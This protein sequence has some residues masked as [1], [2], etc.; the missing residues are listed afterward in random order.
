MT[1]KTTDPKIEEQNQQKDAVDKALDK[2][3]PTQYM[4]NLQIDQNLLKSNVQTEQ[5]KTGVLKQQA[6]NKEAKEQPEKKPMNSEEYILESEAGIVNISLEEYI[7]CVERL[8]ANFE[9]QKKLIDKDFEFK[10]LFAWMSADEL[11]EA[12]KWPNWLDAQQKKLV[13]A[14]EKQIALLDTLIKNKNIELK[15][16]VMPVLWDRDRNHYLTA[17]TNLGR[18]ENS[19]K[20]WQW[21][22]VETFT[23]EKGWTGKKAITGYTKVDQNWNYIA[24]WQ[25]PSSSRQHFITNEKWEVATDYE[26]TFKRWWVP[27]VN[28][29]FLDTFWNLSPKQKNWLAGLMTLGEVA[30][31]VYLGRKAIK[32]IATN[33]DWT[34]S[35]LKALWWVAGI[36]VGSM[37]A[38]GKNP[39]E[40]FG[41]FFNGK[42][43]FDDLTNKL[44]N[45]INTWS[46]SPELTQ[47]IQSLRILNEVPFNALS[48]DQMNTYWGWWLWNPAEYS[49]WRASNRDLMAKNWISVETFDAMFP[50]AIT[51]ETKG[52]FFAKLWLNYAKLSDEEK[53]LKW[54]DVIQRLSDNKELLNDYLSKNNLKVKMWK[55]SALNSYLVHKSLTDHTFTQMWEDGVLEKNIVSSSAEFKDAK[56]SLA[57]QVDNLP[58]LSDLSEGKKQEIKIWIKQFYNSMPEDN[59]PKFDLIEKNGKIYL[60]S[61]R[62][63]YG[64]A[65]MLELNLRDGKLPHF[66]KNDIWI[67]FKDYRWLFAA[68]YATN[69]IINMTKKLETKSQNP[70]VYR[71]LKWVFKLQ[72]FPPIAGFG[73]YFDWKEWDEL[74]LDTQIMSDGLFGWW[75]KMEEISPEIRE[76]SSQYVNY[77][78]W[79]WNNKDALKTT[80]NSDSNSLTA[81]AGA[82]WTIATNLTMNN[83]EGK[84]PEDENKSIEYD[85]KNNPYTKWHELDANKEWN[86]ERWGYGAYGFTKNFVD[87]YAKEVNIAINPDDWI[88]ALDGTTLK[89]RKNQDAIAKYV[90]NKFEKD[91]K[92]VFERWN[93]WADYGPKVMK[94][95]DYYTQKGEDKTTAILRALRMME[96]WGGNYFADE[97]ETRLYW[98]E[99]NKD[100]FESAQ[101]FLKGKD[102]TKL[103]GNIKHNLTKFRNLK[104]Y[105][106]DKGKDV[107]SWLQTDLWL[108]VTGILD[109]K[110]LE[111]IQNYLSDDNVKK[112]EKE[113][114]TK[115]QAAEKE[116]AEKQSQQIE[117]EIKNEIPFMN[118]GWNQN[119]MDESMYNGIARKMYAEVNGVKFAPKLMNNDII[120][121]GNLFINP[122]V[123]V[124][125]RFM[126]WSKVLYIWES[127][128]VNNYIKSDGTF[129][130][131]KFDKKAK[132]TLWKLVLY[133]QI[134]QYLDAGKFEFARIFDTTKKDANIK[135]Y[136]D[137]YKARFS[138]KKFFEMQEVE[139]KRDKDTGKWYLQFDV[140]V[141]W[142]NEWKNEE[143]KRIYFDEITKW[144]GYLDE[145][146]LYQKFHD[147]IVYHIIKPYYNVA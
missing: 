45:I 143:W 133:K 52:Q 59:K 57:S 131:E 103:E 139:M 58:S 124:W 4:K 104:T 60:V 20:A 121:D 24:S 5:V 8:K 13:R 73:I 135:W 63:D 51:E 21:W 119:K 132:E 61:H 110:T 40:L 32:T 48:L 74:G 26:E 77:L 7:Q 141:N 35:R 11:A 34:F 23:E 68:A 98:L 12:R 112:M 107:I 136:V 38:T 122:Y 79:F 105:Y 50:E 33:K 128:N 95:Y 42:L 127:F 30:G 126:Y 85:P 116:K 140:D 82:I 69:G 78:N 86:D 10:D 109:A 88:K 15:E 120:G 97:N 19:I 101:E 55:E 123:Y 27:A 62:T 71:D 80:M 87:T 81:P 37:I 75:G 117:R 9:Q 115:K 96:T 6:E 118:E 142:D 65:R 111:A 22:K 25:M 16:I 2:V 72:N 53:A 46:T 3:I 145:E 29:K 84:N 138:D 41:E 56:E 100:N 93:S 28:R 67:P 64:E 54:R 83:A 1:A 144:D 44:S 137:N 92:K 47:Q 76:Y 147:I 31:V 91:P 17:Y 125:W 39:I 108:T 14:C 18:I 130:K 49:S 94:W 70:F 114:E 129:D 66:V 102:F 146:K 43:S 89:W 36:S 99:E 134:E 113:E 106:D 90:I